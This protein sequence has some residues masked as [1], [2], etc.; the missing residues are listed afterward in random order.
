MHRFTL[1]KTVTCE[2]VYQFDLKTNVVTWPHDTD[3]LHRFNCCA[4]VCVLQVLT[5]DGWLHFKAARRVGA[6]VKALRHQVHIYLVHYFQSML[7]LSSA[8]LLVA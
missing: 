1:T 6:L 7:L 5:V 2:K 3:G 4:T 8:W